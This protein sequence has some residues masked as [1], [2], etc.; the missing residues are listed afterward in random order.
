MALESVRG[1]AEP[2]HGCFLP[3]LSIYL[4]PSDYDGVIIDPC[5]P[6]HWDGFSYTRVY[7]EI[8]C[9]VLSPALPFENARSKKLIVDGEELDGNFL[10]YDKIKG[11][12]S[13][14]IKVVY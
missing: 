3:L 12:K 4:V 9:T 8:S 5:V 14:E 10:P 11:K 6:A 13:V 1:S 7:R 2:R